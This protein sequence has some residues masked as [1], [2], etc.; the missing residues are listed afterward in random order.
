MVRKC[1]ILI[2]MSQEAVEKN[3]KAL[4]EGGL[5]LIDSTNIK[6]VPKIKAKI[7]EIPATETSKKAL[8][9]KLCKYDNA[10]R[11]NKNNR[12]NK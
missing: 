10:W 1:D 8:G 9:E 3:V 4:K 11:S 5:R 2:A 7:C 6:S 12:Y